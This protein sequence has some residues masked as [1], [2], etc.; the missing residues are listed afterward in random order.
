MRFGGFSSFSI[1][2]GLVIGTVSAVNGLSAVGLKA[3]ADSPRWSEWQLASN[4]R[5]LIYGLG[6]FLSVGQLP[7][8]KSAH[9]F[10]RDAD[11]DGNSLRS[12]CVYVLQGTPSKARWWTISV[13]TGSAL[14]AQSELTAGEAVVANDGVLSVVISSRPLPGNW[15]VPPSTST[16]SVHYVLHEPDADETNKL[17]SITKKGC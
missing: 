10:V 3:V 1:F 4:D 12:D 15:I 14:S 11:E 8:S 13:A 5:F 16:Y 2:L 9:M 17:P 7:P 6:H